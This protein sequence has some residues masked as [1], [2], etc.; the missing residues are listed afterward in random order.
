MKISYLVLTHNE[1]QALDLIDYLNRYKSAQDEII[2]LNDPVTDEYEAELK[3]RGVTVVNH[4]LNY[5]YSEHRNFALPYCKGEWIFAL[6]ADELPQKYLLTNIRAILEE[7]IAD[8]L[9]LPRL[10]IFDG[11]TQQDAVIYGWNIVNGLVN[12]PDYQSRIFR[13]GVG[14]QWEGNLHE[15]L[16]ANPEHTQ[17]MLKED[18]CFSIVHRKTI[19]QQRASN[20]HYNKVYTEAENRGIKT[21][22]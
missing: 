19:E 17:L 18:A 20:Q 16:K 5:S 15:R 8:V 12:W 9:W 11:L 21:N 22:A 6:D 2:I 7:T 1:A 4:K 3:A 10:N 14:I 13:N